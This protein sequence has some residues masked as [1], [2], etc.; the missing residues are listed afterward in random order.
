MVGG[1]GKKSTVSNSRRRR[2]HHGVRKGPADTPMAPLSMDLGDMRDSDSAA[3]DVLSAVGGGTS[4]RTAILDVVSRLSRPKG[5]AGLGLA[6]DGGGTPRT[7]E[8]LES[9]VPVH[10]AGNPKAWEHRDAVHDQL[11]Q[12]P[13]LGYGRKVVPRALVQ[14]R[15]DSLL[16]MYR[17]NTDGAML[18]LSE[19]VRAAQSER[20][21]NAPH[22]QVRVQAAVEEATAVYLST[23][24]QAKV[25]PYAVIHQVKRD[26]EEHVEGLLKHRTS[27][28]M[29]RTRNEQRMQRQR[30]RLEEVHK[31]KREATLASTQRH[32]MLVLAAQAQREAELLNETQ[33]LWLTW[34][35][36]ALSLQRFAVTLL[37]YRTFQHLVNHY[38]CMH[39]AWHVWLAP[40]IEKA[41]ARHYL[42]MRGRWRFALCAARLLAYRQVRKSTI[43]AIILLLQTQQSSQRF[44]ASVHRFKRHVLVMQRCIRRFISMRRARLAL[45]LIQ[46]DLVESDMRHPNFSPIFG[47]VMEQQPHTTGN[48]SG[49]GGAPSSPSSPTLLGG[50]AAA[51]T[52]IMSGRPHKQGGVGG[53]KGASGQSS[54]A[55]NAAKAEDAAVNDMC[56]KD[57][58]ELPIP[59]D[60]RIHACKEVLR[61][62][63]RHFYA[64]EQPGLA[65]LDEE[66]YQRAMA[67]F[68]HLPPR[69]Q[70]PQNQPKKPRLR[71]LPLF[72]RRSVM[73]HTIQLYLDAFRALITKGK[74][75]LAKDTLR[76]GGNVADYLAR[77]EAVIIQYFRVQ[78]EAARAAFATRYRVTV[79][80]SDGAHCSATL[81]AIDE[82]NEA[83]VAAL[84]NLARVRGAASFYSGASPTNAS[85]HGIGSFVADFV[86]ADAVEVAKRHPS[87]G[88]DPALQKLAVHIVHVLQR[89]T[90]AT[91]PANQPV[92]STNDGQEHKGGS[93]TRGGARVP[94]NRAR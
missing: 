82:R 67:A 2:D 22:V 16:E 6:A 17:G 55:A 43:G 86:S 66:E 73:L 15:M 26:A 78:D 19:R 45:L 89:V 14:Q 93:A 47:R 5:S 23:H 12:D 9:L 13:R 60:V 39:R 79:P 64:V 31:A 50:A 63:S 33:R 81:N 4:P 53:A 30:K 35:A 34:S 21:L 75:L 1:G 28:D 20:P 46:W 69:K 27:P 83:A 38:H 58:V 8:P 88:N 32:E 10:H 91:S 84:S 18:M 92:A 40:A 56:Q 94:V 90:E 25:V 70:I 59:L 7:Y 54:S 62:H 85:H 74:M 76:S 48:S 11:K 68:Y 72:A 29:C 61:S 87:H 24:R 36:S 51:P 77:R 52:R 49:T 44:I 37:Q 41:K 71:T 57:K 65:K 3:Q 80:R 42:K